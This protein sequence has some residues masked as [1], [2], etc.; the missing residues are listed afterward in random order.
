MELY[1]PFD[2]DEPETTVIVHEPTEEEKIFHIMLGIY[3]EIPSD[4][5]TCYD[6]GIWERINRQLDK[7]IARGHS[8]FEEYR[9]TPRHTA[10][11]VPSMNYDPIRSSLM[12]ALQYM[13]VQFHLADPLFLLHQHDKSGGNRIYNMATSESHSNQSQNQTQQQSQQITFDQMIETALSG[14]KEHYDQPIVDEAKVKL[15]SLKEN[16]NWAHVKAVLSWIL[17]TGKEAALA[18]IPVILQYY[19]KQ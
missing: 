2:D 5:P 3:N 16:K 13:H 14:L 7:L 6:P 11:G 4:K 8:E 19:L 12:A 1:D 18:A 17:E 10:S 9:L 15:E